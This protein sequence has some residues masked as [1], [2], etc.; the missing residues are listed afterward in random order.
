MFHWDHLDQELG[1]NVLDITHIQVEE[2]IS[3]QN[4]HQYM[5]QLIN[6]NWIFHTREV[7]SVVY[8]R[9]NTIRINW[10][11][12][13]FRFCIKHKI[14]NMIQHSIRRVLNRIKCRRNRALNV[15]IRRNRALNM[16][17][18][19]TVGFVSVEIYLSLFTY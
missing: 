9:L 2:V 14:C 7:I 19:S 10:H 15:Q 17:A 16:Y 3:V 4:Q 6:L 1:P 12:V 5:D 8:H 18:C 13:L 11:L